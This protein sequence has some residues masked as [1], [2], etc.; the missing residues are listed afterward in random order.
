MVSPTE[1]R[2]ASTGPLG[3]I[4]VLTPLPVPIIMTTLVLFEG[5]Y[6]CCR[7]ADAVTAPPL[8]RSQGVPLISIALVAV[9]V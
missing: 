1:C 6:A 5:L 3:A 4:M 9:V 7:S 2:L 8:R